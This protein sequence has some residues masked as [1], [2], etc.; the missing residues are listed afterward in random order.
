VRLKYALWATAAWTVIG[1]GA[2]AAVLWYI[3]THPVRGA[4]A[5]DRAA[6]AGQAAGIV[7]A[8]GYGV[9]W[10]PYAAAVGRKRREARA[11]EGK[12]RTG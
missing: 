7:V 10:L 11:A 5:R 4:R 8:A 12:P 1:V 9:I 2:S 3:S 6:V